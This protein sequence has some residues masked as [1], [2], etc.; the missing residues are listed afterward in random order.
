M[1]FWFIECEGKYG[2]YFKCSKLDGF[3][4]W[5]GEDEHTSWWSIGRKD[6]DNNETIVVYQNSI[7]VN[8]LQNLY[9]ALTREELI[10]KAVPEKLIE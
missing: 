8:Q 10:I 3:R 4:V 6:Y 7:S 9:F 2:T 5:H 1:K